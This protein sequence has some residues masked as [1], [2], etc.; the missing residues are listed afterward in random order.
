[1]DMITKLLENRKMLDDDYYYHNGQLMCP[2]NVV[3]ES[4]TRAYGLTLRYGVREADKLILPD[5]RVIE[6]AIL[7][8][9]SWQ[10]KEAA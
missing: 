4:G 10:K 3:F 5:G 2:I 6:P 1:M 9:G 8:N 7:E